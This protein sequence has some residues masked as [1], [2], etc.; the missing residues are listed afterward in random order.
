MRRPCTQRYQRVLQHN[1]IR[2]LLTADHNVSMR[3]LRPAHRPQ[4]IPR[5]LRNGTDKPCDPTL[6]GCPDSP[7][8][9]AAGPSG[10]H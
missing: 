3:P 1:M 9:K 6:F 5:T 8:A 2:L 10:R 7:M 4:T